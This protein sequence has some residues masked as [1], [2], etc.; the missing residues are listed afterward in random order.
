MYALN[1]YA[2]NNLFYFI[3]ILLSYTYIF[4]V[5]IS[6]LYSVAN[7]VSADCQELNLI[8]FMFNE[9]QYDKRI[10]PSVGQN[11]PLNVTVGLTIHRIEDLV[12]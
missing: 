10:I 5:D 6:K 9:S 2:L 12:R 4:N 1:F 3:F 11:G 8:R 7:I